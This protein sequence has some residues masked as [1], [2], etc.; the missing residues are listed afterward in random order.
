M[1]IPTSFLTCVS[2]VFVCDFFL[3]PHPA[4]PPSCNAAL[5]CRPDAADG[6]AATFDDHEESV[7]G[8]AWSAADPWL[9]ASL[10]YDGRL[11]LN[12]V[13]KAL[14]YRILI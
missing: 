8:L 13:P 14:Q 6:K 11:V 1:Y 12:R 4:I 2:F 7:Y 9:F 10:S 5:P 3:P